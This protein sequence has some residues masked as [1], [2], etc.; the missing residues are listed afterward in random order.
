[1]APVRMPKIPSLPTRSWARLGPTLFFTVAMP[2]VWTSPSSIRASTD[3]TQWRVMPY[4]Q[5]QGPPALVA[6]LPPKAHWSQ[7]LGSG[8]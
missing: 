3:S 8:G 6:R 4:L 5:A 7:E 1:M 2:K